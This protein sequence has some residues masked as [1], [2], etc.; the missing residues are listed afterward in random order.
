MIGDL[1]FIIWQKKS[2]AWVLGGSILK[3]EEIAVTRRAR[4][5]G[6][7]SMAAMSRRK[8]R[9]LWVGDAERPSAHWLWSS[10]RI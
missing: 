6:Q 1:T 5:E 7:E 3:G 2:Q 8:S 4:D 9:A 10:R